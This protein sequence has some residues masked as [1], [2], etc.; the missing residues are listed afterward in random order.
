MTYQPFLP[1]VTAGSVEARHAAVSLRRHLRRT[2][3]IAGAARRR[4]TTRTARSTVRT[5]DG[6]DREL[7]YD[8]DRRHRRRR[9]PHVPRPGLAQ[10]AIGLK[11][12]EEAVAIRDRL[13]TAFDR[14]A[15]LPPGRRAPPAAHGHRSSAAGSP[16][17]RASASCCRWPRR[18]CAPTRS[19]AADDLDLPPRRGERPHPARGHRRARAAGWC[20]RLERRGAHVHLDTQLV[21]AVDGHVVLSTGEEFDSGSDR[22]DRR[23]RP[24]TPSSPGTPTCPVDERGPARASGPTSAS[25]PTSDP[26]PDAW[27]AGDDAAVPDLASPVPGARDRAERAARRT[28]GQAPREEHRRRPARQ[29]GPKHYLHH[30]LGVVATL[31]LG[32]R[33]LPVPA[34]RHQ[35]LPG[36]AD[37]PRLPRPGR[38]D[39]GAQ[40]PRARRLADR[41]VLR[42]GHRLRSPRSSTRAPRSSPAATRSR[43]PTARRPPTRRRPTANGTA[44]DDAASRPELSSP[45]ELS[46]VRD[47][48]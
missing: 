29:E 22:L 27:A 1:E 48:S 35:G 20:A 15:M 34:H 42:P 9:D 31:G 8:I 41:G 10:Q 21:S 40:G 30:S 28:A 18:C 37:A 44:V 25:A 7:A 5:D 19:S 36:L 23:Q 12:V 43:G 26:V 3:I 16:A 2:T 4:S 45:P 33:H 6:A 38:P 47:A 14:A 32:Q 11:H 24:R 39:L 17:S 46:V 13:L